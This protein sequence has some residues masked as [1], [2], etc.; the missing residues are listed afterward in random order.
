MVDHLPITNPAVLQPAPDLTTRQLRELLRKE[1]AEYGK[2]EKWAYAHG[3]SKS[4]FYK[5]RAGKCKPSHAVAAALGY[6]Q[7][8]LWRRK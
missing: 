4:H 6:E 7:V 8:V 5:V 3:I 1:T 2:R